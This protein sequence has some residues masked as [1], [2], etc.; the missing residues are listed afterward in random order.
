MNKKSYK[1]EFLKTKTQLLE[2]KMSNIYNFKNYYQSK[3]CR[4]K[5]QWNW[6]I[7]IETVQN[8]EMKISVLP[9]VAWSAISNG[10]LYV[11]GLLKEN[12]MRE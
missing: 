5:D 9:C 12:K 1:Q 4:I 10:L 2:K 11:I 3:N 8:E 7:G 6:Y